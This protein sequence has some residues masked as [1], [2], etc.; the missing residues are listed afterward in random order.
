MVSACLSL[1]CLVNLCKLHVGFCCGMVKILGMHLFVK[2]VVV[3]L[4]EI[5]MV[6]CVVGGCLMV[7]VLS[8]GFGLVANR[9]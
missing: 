5:W 3:F 4:Q 6:F 7:V 1:F 2:M 8:Y 9:G